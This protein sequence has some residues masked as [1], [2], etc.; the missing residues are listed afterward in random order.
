MLAARENRKTMSISF[1]LV[2]IQFVFLKFSPVG[3]RVSYER[4]VSLLLQWDLTLIIWTTLKYTDLDS[5]NLLICTFMY[6][7]K[8]GKF[9]S[10]E[11]FLLQ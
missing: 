9:M 1:K 10:K 4:S 11:C 5:K 7:V 6:E 3:A 2:I 8:Y